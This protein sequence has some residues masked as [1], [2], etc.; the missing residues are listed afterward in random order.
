MF[1]D[2]RESLSTKTKRRRFYF[3]NNASSLN[4]IRKPEAVWYVLLKLHNIPERE[5]KECKGRLF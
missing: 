2:S 4:S 1:L 5:E 3:L